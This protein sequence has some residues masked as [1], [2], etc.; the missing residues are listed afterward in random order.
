MTIAQSVKIGV[1]D[2][3]WKIRQA[4]VKQLT[5]QT[6]LGKI[7]V[8]DNHWEVRRAAVGKVINQELLCQWA[9]KDPQA[10]IRQAAVAQI[11][12]DSFLLTQLTTESSTAVH[13]A[14]INTLHNKDSIRI[15]ALKA[16]HRKDREQALERL[17]ELSD[18][19]HEKINK[20]VIS[21]KELGRMAEELANE[22]DNSKLL[23]FV[24]EGKFDVLRIAAAHQLSDPDILKQAALRTDYR[25]VQKI[26][27]SKLED[28]IMLSQIAQESENHA[29]RLAAAQKAG[30]KSWQEIFDVSSDIGPTVNAATAQKAGS[31][32]TIGDALAAVSLF[33]NVQTDAMSAVQDVCLNLIKLGNESRIPEMVDLLEDYGDETLAED[34]LN[35]GQPDLNDAGRKWAHSRGYKI[36]IGDG[37]HR[38]TWGIGR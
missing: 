3:H 2:N 34:Y 17:K 13:A 1:E 14:I 35:C 33:Q 19:S 6:L 25:E 8:E 21:H 36:N 24:L 31:N 37:S 9:K 32:H 5:D 23:T 27:L 20:V 10:A 22:I 26:L 16:F 4:A 28:K 7:A 11:S 18:A 15:C 12:D 29:M 30:S 38:A